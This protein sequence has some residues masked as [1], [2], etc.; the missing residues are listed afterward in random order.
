MGRCVRFTPP[1]QEMG[2]E[3][4]L[5]RQFRALIGSTTSEWDDVACTLPKTGQTGSKLARMAQARAVFAQNGANRL[6]VGQNG[7]NGGSFLGNGE[8]E[9]LFRGQRNV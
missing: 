2:G 9:A 6:E 7:P 3:F 1:Q 5:S 4:H 8:I